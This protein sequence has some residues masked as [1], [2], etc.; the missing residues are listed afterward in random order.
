MAS[1]YPAD[2]CT[3]RWD[4]AECPVSPEAARTV[5]LVL[6]VRDLLV[7]AKTGGA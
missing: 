3:K 4:A 7:Q 5:V 1:A 6:H 2:S